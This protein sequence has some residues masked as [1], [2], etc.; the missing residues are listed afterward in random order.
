VFLA[1]LLQ[2]VVYNIKKEGLA[3][4]V[5]NPAIDGEKLAIR[6][7][8]PAIGDKKL[9]IE[10]LESAIRRQNYNEPTIKNMI[11]IYDVIET[12]QIFGAPE[13]KNIL[14]Y[15]ISISKEI[16]KKLRDIEVVRSVKGKG[17]GKYRFVNSEEIEK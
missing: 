12:D 10:I 6:N 5:C 9:A 17:K 15:S 7:E 11:T 16:M 4:N 3:F 1:F 13:V 14:K 2:T 8:K